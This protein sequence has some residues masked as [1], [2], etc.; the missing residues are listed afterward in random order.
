MY[1]LCQLAEIF[2]LEIYAATLILLWTL[3]VLRCVDFG[4]SGSSALPLPLEAYHVAAAA[5]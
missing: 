4:N 3:L 2:L 5:A 1:L